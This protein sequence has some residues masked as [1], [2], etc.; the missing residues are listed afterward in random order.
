MTAAIDAALPFFEERHRELWLRALAFVDSDVTPLAAEDER[1]PAAS[2][3]VYATRLARAGLLRH[4]VANDIRAVALV[5]AALARATALADS[6][7]AM[8]GLSALPIVLHGSESQKREWLPRLESGVIGA[9]ALT[10]PEA[11][12]DPAGMRLEAKRDG[13]HYRL[14]GVKT[15]I[16]NAGLAEIVVLFA[17]TGEGTENAFSAFVLPGD[18]H[19]LSARPIE[20]IAPHPIGTLE[21]DAV[22]VPE[23][24]RLGKEG[25]GLRVAFATLDR[26]RSTVGAAACGMAW[27]AL[28]EARLHARTRSQF[29]HPLEKFQATQFAIAEMATALE[30]SWLLVA[31]ATAA[32]DA[33]AL[34]TKRLAA[35]AKLF[36]TDE[37]HA[38]VDRALQIHG[39]KGLVRGSPVERLYRDVRALRIYEG[40]SE[41]QKLVIAREISLGR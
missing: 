18:A 12:S 20:L 5:R 30:A 23:S 6:A 10:E 36:A 14:S 4:A 25:D 41:I 21:L 29:G 38:I 8:Q 3:R 32:A 16:S 7:F 1:E 37:A 22:R 39:G 11:G 35:S 33:G 40:T 19:G 31:R 2:T 26:F 34:A 28:D 15:F 13:D 24:A 17:R 27:R 9:F